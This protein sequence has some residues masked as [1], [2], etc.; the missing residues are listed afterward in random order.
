MTYCAMCAMPI[1]REVDAVQALAVDGRPL[2]ICGR[3]IDSIDHRPRNEQ[4]RNYEGFYC[5]TCGSRSPRY[6]Y[7]GK[8]T[9]L[10]SS[11]APRFKYMLYNQLQQALG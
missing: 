1:V 8:N 4:Y 2:W 9:S 11:C 7:H 3:C 6:L 10:C 5:S